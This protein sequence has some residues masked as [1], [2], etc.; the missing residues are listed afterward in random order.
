MY[1]SAT[2]LCTPGSFLQSGTFGAALAPSSTEGD[3]YAPS[4]CDTSDAF[5]Y[6]T[7]ATTSACIMASSS[8]SS[9]NAAYL[10]CL[11]LGAHLFVLRSMDKLDLLPHGQGY[12]IGLTDLAVEGTFVWQDTGDVIT[13]D[14]K[15]LFFRSREPNNNGVGEDCTVVT[16]GTGSPSG[17]DLP[18]DFVYYKFV[19]ERPVYS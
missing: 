18:C 1:N 16:A 13:K 8:V 17:N 10:Y 12:I 2:G 6:V 9:Y 3:L 7:S 14:L 15:L 4:V 19:C 11:N 5:T